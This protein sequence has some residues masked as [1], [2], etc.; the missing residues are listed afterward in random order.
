MKSP[1]AMEF[2]QTPHGRN[3]LLFVLFALSC[4]NF[5]LLAQ[6]IPPMINYQGQLAS[7]SGAPLA[8]A[9]YALSFSIYDSA[10]NM[11]TPIWGPEIFDGIAGQGHGAQVPVVRGYF[12][13]IL[14]PWDTN[15][16]SLAN[17]FSATSRYLQITVGTNPPILPRQAVLSVPFAMQTANSAALAGTNWAALFG[18]ND[19]V[20]GQLPGSRIAGGSITAAQ[21][22]SGS[23]QGSNLASGTI[24]AVQIASNT[25]TLANLASRQTGTNN[26]GLGGVATSGDSGEQDITTQNTVLSITNLSVK[27]T[28]SGRPVYVGL[29]PSGNPAT[30]TQS[31]V[32][33]NTTANGVTA[34]VYIMRGTNCVASVNPS[35]YSGSTG[36]IQVGFPPSS[37]QTIDFPPSAG[38]WTYSVQCLFYEGSEVIFKSVTLAAFE[39]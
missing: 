23:I 7:P 28:T 15:G 27:I 11:N 20:N 31:S 36:G 19:P 6:T 4:G 5:A 17:A 1:I 12:N 33:F 13:V 22:G 39:L 29:I 32:I 30:N 18:T 21:I 25:I 10:T 14:G 34:Y 26:V 16:N 2:T 24:T 3:A 8:T 9:D 37:F 38:T 35:G